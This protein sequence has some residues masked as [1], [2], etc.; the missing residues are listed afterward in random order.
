[1]AFKNAATSGARFER[2]LPEGE[3]A[4]Q[5]YSVGTP[6]GQKVTILLE[7][8]GVAYDAWR[9]NIMK[10]DNF[11]S[12]FVRISPNEK[13]PALVDRDGP[14]G[15]GEHC[16]MESGAI[17]MYLAEKFES[18]L[19]PKAPRE[20]STVTQWVMWQMGTGPYLG[21]FGHFAVYAKEKIPYAIDRY[22][23]ETKRILDV[24]DK[25]LERTGAYVAGDSYTIADIAI[26]PWIVCLDLF[27][28]AKEELGL[29]SY[30]HVQKWIE[31]I[32]KRDAV[33][34]GMQITGFT[35][36]SNHYSTPGKS[37]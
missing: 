10:G 4:L 35:E 5:L 16:V 23:M 1:M 13:I 3:H 22:T 18:D 26:F 9:I 17:L 6:N 34:R 7:E 30:E 27:Y 8:L 37:S 36:D 21:Q 11:S 12:G 14:D 19:Y 32:A 2:D 28:K 24:L 33:M 29:K 20:R 15:A 31:N 25:Q